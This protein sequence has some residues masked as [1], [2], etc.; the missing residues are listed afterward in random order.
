MNGY[1]GMIAAV[2]AGGLERTVRFL[3]RLPPLRPGRK[4]GRRGKPDRTPRHHD[5]R[6]ACPPEKRA[7]LGIVDGLVRISVGV[8]DVDDLIDDFRQALE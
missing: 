7:A 4:P 6:R 8:E 1:G 3:G 2:I 5:P